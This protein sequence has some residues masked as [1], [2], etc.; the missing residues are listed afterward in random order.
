M[1]EGATKR[2]AAANPPPRRTGNCRTAVS[3]VA[4]GVFAVLNGDGAWGLSNS[5]VLAQGGTAVVVDTM[6]VPEMA[7]AVTEQLETHGLTPELVLNT[8]HHLDHVGGNSAFPDVPV[9]ALPATAEIVDKMSDDLGWLPGLFPEHADRLMAAGLR[10]PQPLRGDPGELILPRSA[11]PLAFAQAHSPA[12]L[13]VWVPESRVLISGDLC[14]NGVVPLA[15]HG[16]IAG[17]TEALDALLALDPTT[18]VPGHGPPT[19]AAT[20]RTL[21]DYFTH[22]SDVA[23]RAVAAGASAE[24]AW[25]EADPGELA[26]W[27]EPDRTLVNLRV[28]M[29][30]AAGT[31]LPLGPPQRR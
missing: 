8:H 1:S 4:D 2:S 19:T 16:R 6:L 24:D 10:V 12:D 27:H 5:T 3:E 9:M 13:A 21:R 20:L 15:R 11:R 29:A 31:P 22:V 7:H 23:E 30:E 28:A 26:E 17:W 25:H 14:F 18:V